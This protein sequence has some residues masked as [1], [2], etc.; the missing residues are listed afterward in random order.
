MEKGE[1]GIRL[2]IEVAPSRVLLSDFHLWHYP[3]NL[4]PLIP[5]EI[6][7]AK[8]EADLKSAGF[9]PPFDDRKFQAL[10]KANPRL[11]ERF[12]GSW[13]LIFDL[14]W[15][16]PDYTDSIENKSIQAVLWEIKL[17]DIRKVDRFISR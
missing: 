15:Q 13:E 17:S 1:A 2:E 5:N 4:W 8:L 11:A 3:L 10:I 6:E 9:S 16:N 12:T 14:S 7:E